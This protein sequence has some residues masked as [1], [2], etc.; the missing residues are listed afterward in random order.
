MIR[1]RLLGLILLFSGSAMAQGVHPAWPKPTS[2]RQ[3]QMRALGMG[4]GSV[5]RKPT[6]WERQMQL[7]G[8]GTAGSGAVSGRGFSPLELCADIVH[9]DGNDVEGRN[10]AQNLSQS[11]A[12]NGTN[13]TSSGSPADFQKLVNDVNK[14]QAKKLAEEINQMDFRDSLL[15]FWAAYERFN[16]P[17]EP[18]T[19]DRALQLAMSGFKDWFNQTQATPAG[20]NDSQILKGA[21]QKYWESYQK[22]SSGGKVKRITEAEMTEGVNQFNLAQKEAARL[23]GAIKRDL[24]EIQKSNS[25]T[26]GDPY[27]YRTAQSD[28]SQSDF[29]LNTKQAEINAW[30]RRRQELESKNFEALNDLNQRISQSVG[31]IVLGS[32]AYRSKYPRVSM[33]SCLSG[34]IYAPLNVSE[35]KS[36]INPMMSGIQKKFY[37]AQ[38]R[39][40]RGADPSDIEGVLKSDPGLVVKL[41]DQKKSDPTTIAILCQKIRGINAND[42]MWYYTKVTGQVVAGIAGA[43]LTVSGVGS[44][45][46]VPMLELSATLA[47]AVS[48]GAYAGSAT[49][50][51][52]I[53]GDEARTSAEVVRAE[54]SFYASDTQAR[55]NNLSNLQGASQRLEQKKSEVL[56]DLAL[57][58]APEAGMGAIGALVRL[59]GVQNEARLKGFADALD[60]E[61]SHL[62]PSQKVAIW[63]E[64]QRTDPKD[65]GV[66]W[67]EQRLAEVRKTYPVG[68]SR[69]PPTDS[70]TRIGPGAGVMDQISLDKLSLDPDLNRRSMAMEYPAFQKH[71]SQTEV[72]AVFKLGEDVKGINSSY[73]VELADGT[74]GIWKPRVSIE[75]GRNTGLQSFYGDER[76]EA[77]AYSVSELFALDLVPKTT[78]KRIPLGGRPVYGSF[79]L[80]ESNS[81]LMKNSTVKPGSSDLIKLD[82]FDYL[83]ENGDRHSGN[84]MVTKD[85]KIRAIDNG[86]S[87]WKGKSYGEFYLKRRNFGTNVRDWSPVERNTSLVAE[88]LTRNAFGEPEKIR[89]WLFTRD[90]MN[91]EERLLK[92]D[93]SSIRSEIKQQ[94]PWLSDRELDIYSFRIDERRKRLMD[95]L[96]VIKEFDGKNSP[97]LNQRL[98]Q[99]LNI[100]PKNHLINRLDPSATIP[101]DRDATR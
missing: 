87:F 28:H 58:W 35:L 37:S 85:G 63:D 24:D 70:R 75:E 1:V 46:G 84:F 32:E 81:V 41:I 83:I 76:N 34:R 2:Q 77:L 64:I 92:L 21:I 68:F 93:R 96:A 101:A 38:R 54:Q 44:W 62:T 47:G 74:T 13:K 61:H 59:K 95:S 67:L 27:H 18:R 53:L 42:S 45:I 12:C 15:S 20:I 78:L 4:G 56:E 39:L 99:I 8:M 89:T 17:I 31:A 86:I 49:A 3:A 40:V 19:S 80:F 26:G 97:V 9:R 66:Q 22:L 91:L 30:E 60:R 65:L 11:A 43:V 94:Q 100:F 6:E 69:V 33:E 23:C 7:L 52:A 73:L 50:T 16:G 10:I 71:V 55:V 88:G 57:T 90:G 72:K 5:T 82:I 79:Q 29:R 48:F 98:N 25:P 14:N 51:A 36:E